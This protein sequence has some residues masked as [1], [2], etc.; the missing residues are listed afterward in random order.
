MLTVCDRKPRIAVQPH[1]SA[2]D[3]GVGGGGRGGG[4]VKVSGRKCSEKRRGAQGVNRLTPKSLG[5]ELQEEGP[6]LPETM[7]SFFHL[8]IAFENDLSLQ[9]RV[10]SFRPCF[11]KL[12]QTRTSSVSGR[13]S[14]NFSRLVRVRAADLFQF[15]LLCMGLYGI[16][17][18]WMGKAKRNSSSGTCLLVSNTGNSTGSTDST[19]WS[20]QC[21]SYSM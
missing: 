18:L 19:D 10:P 15:V 5:L 4:G 7:E 11:I 21:V 14:S 20:A 12:F 13:V 17:T 16:C 2:A 1:F 3:T 8:L 6:L 9:R